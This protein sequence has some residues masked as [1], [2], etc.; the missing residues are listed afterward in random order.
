MLGG[1]Y[2]SKPG[3]FDYDR[4][5]TVRY[6]YEP[7]A[8]AF[9][10]TAEEFFQLLDSIICHRWGLPPSVGH[11]DSTQVMFGSSQWHE[12]SNGHGSM[13]KIVGFSTHIELQAMFCAASEMLKT[14]EV[15]KESYSDG[16]GNLWE[17]W[18]SGWD[19]KSPPHWPSDFRN[20]TPLEQ[21]FWVNPTREYLSLIHI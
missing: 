1:P 11:L 17:S 13:P 5:D 19:L 12:F 2:E 6:W 18:I 9:E 3:R 4:M 21:Q 7:L 10:I 14:R 20:A 16:D 8:R 15:H